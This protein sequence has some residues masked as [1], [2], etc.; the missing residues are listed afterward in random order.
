M[1]SAAARARRHKELELEIL[2][3]TVRGW[4]GENIDQ[5]GDIFK[6]GCVTVYNAASPGTNKQDDRYLVLFP[7]T[8]LILSVSSRMS[9]FI[10]EVGDIPC[11]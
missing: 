11:V 7:S 6:M 5:M 2:T 3:G 8:L 9:A 1:A 4:E 10:Y